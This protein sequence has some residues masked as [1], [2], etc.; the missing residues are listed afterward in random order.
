MSLRENESS[1][2]INERIER[3]KAT[4]S[5]AEVLINDWR[6]YMRS[7]PSFQRVENEDALYKTDIQET[8]DFEGEQGGIWYSEKFLTESMG[9][10]ELRVLSK[11]SAQ[12][13][14]E[15]VS[16]EIRTTQ[17]FRHHEGNA[18]PTGFYSFRVLSAH[19]GPTNSPETEAQIRELL[20]KQRDPQ[21]TTP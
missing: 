17:G 1:L 4:H 12:G 18:F 8:A 2:S 11:T 3:E 21:T 15:G 16:V 19:Q 7:L 14:V 9:T 13:M 6:E 20:T 10:K 5:K